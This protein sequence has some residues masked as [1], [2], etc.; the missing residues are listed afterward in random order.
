MMRKGLA[1]GATR[2]VLVTDPALA[3]ADLADDDPRPC[4]GRGRRGVR[5]AARGRRH[6]RRAGRRRRRRASRRCSGCRYLSNAASI[7][8]D[9]AAGRVRVRRLTAKGYDVDRGADARA[10]SRAPRP[11]GRRATRRL[12]GIMAA[13]S[14]EIALKAR[15]RPGLDADVARGRRLGD[16]GRRPRTPAGPCRGTRRARR[17][18]RGGTRGRRLPGRPEA[19]LMAAGHPGRRPRSPTAP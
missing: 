5:P 1:M 10:S 8:P 3:G 19:H 17:P 12:K 15:G 4:R 9:P 11:S 2:G 18:G 16:A 13:R 7:E 14:R 6:V